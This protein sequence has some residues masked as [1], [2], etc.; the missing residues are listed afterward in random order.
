[1]FN[2]S[3]FNVSDI[4]VAEFIMMTAES[5]PDSI[6]WAHL[7]SN[8]DILPD[9]NWVGNPNVD[10]FVSSNFTLITIE[11]KQYIMFTPDLYVYEQDTRKYVG[12][13]STNTNT[14]EKTLPYYEE[15]LED[16]DI[17]IDIK[18]K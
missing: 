4:M 14:I 11:G 13:W 6:D 7:S 17:E 2:V 15:E 8:A 18:F 10:P 16:E 1:M 9:S 5:I 3:E 12:K